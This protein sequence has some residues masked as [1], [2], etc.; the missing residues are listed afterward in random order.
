MKTIILI[1]SILTITS[2]SISKNTR[3]LSTIEIMQIYEY[4]YNTG[5]NKLSSIAGASYK[6]SMILRTQEF[7]KDSLNMVKIL[8]KK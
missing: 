5:W 7:K 6:E 2:C 3:R 8:N 1:L 4:G